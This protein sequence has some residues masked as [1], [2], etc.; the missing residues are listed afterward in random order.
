M[1]LAAAHVAL[2]TLPS[3]LLVRL[4]NLVQGVAHTWVEMVALEAA[5]PAR[6]TGDMSIEMLLA[7]LNCLHFLRKD[8]QL[9]AVRSVEKDIPFASLSA[10]QLL[11]L[12]P[13]T[14]VLILSDTNRAHYLRRCA[15]LRLGVQDKKAYHF[16]HI[17]AFVQ[18]ER[19]FA[20]GAITVAWLADMCREA[21]KYDAACLTAADSFIA[22]RHWQS[23]AGRKLAA[24]LRPLGGCVENTMEKVEGL[25]VLPLV[26]RGCVIHVLEPSD[27]MLSCTK[28]HIPVLHPSV[29]LR[30][31]LLSQ[32]GYRVVTITAKK[33]LESDPE[34]LRALLEPHSA[35]RAL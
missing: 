7:V 13:T 25:F 19:L 16:R 35:R 23:T 18:M 1:S 8:V 6:V 34:Q 14:V 11:Q 3:V 17:G 30:H 4:L 10:E 31:K 24:A 28:S 5:R 20:P 22:R 29:V 32:S 26:V 33:C 9:R 21:D 27:C 15:E 2:D 12:T